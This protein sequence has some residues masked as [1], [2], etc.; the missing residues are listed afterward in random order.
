MMPASGRLYLYPAIAAQAD[1]DSLLCRLAWYFQAH[2]DRIAAIHMVAPRAMLDTA[3]LAPNIDPAVATMLPAVRRKMQPLDA[4]TF[5]KHLSAVDPKADILLLW[6][7]TA[8][9]EAPAPVRAAIKALGARQAFYRV[10]PQR[11]RMEGS[12]WLWAGLNRFADV[13]ALT[14]ANRARFQEMRAEIGHHDKAY[15]FG[16]GPSLTSF[17]ERH[18]FSDGLAIAANSIVK[19]AAVVARIRP[20]IIAA[21]DPLYHAGVSTYA[22]AF[23][24]ELVQALRDSGAWFV[25]P[26]RDFPIYDAVLPEDLRP[27]VI[28]IPFD[29]DAPP[30]HD[31]GATFALRPYPNVLTLALLPLAATFADRIDIVGCDGR[32]LTDDGFFWSHD[33]KVQFMD[34]MAEIQ[35]A[36]PAFFKIDYND[37]YSDHA[38]DV[39]IVAQ[40]LEAAGKRLVT[41]TPSRI[42]AL[43]AREPLAP[44][45]QPTLVMLD[46]DA[47]DDWGHFLAYDKRIAEG[48][49]ARGMRVALL[50]RNDLDPAFHPAS[51]AHTVPVFSVHSWA[52]G[53]RKTGDQH[54][55]DVLTFARALEAGLDRLETVI[56]TGPLCLFLYVGS[57]ELAEIVEHVIAARPRL[58]AVVN[59]FW[60]YNFDESDPAYRAR[61]QPVVARMQTGRTR[62]RLTHSTPQIA[63]DFQRHWG[64]NIP[65]L[66]HPSTTFGDAAA[67]ACAAALAAPA[68][69]AIPGS[70]LRVLFPGG[71]RQEKGFVLSL[72]TAAALAR[73]AALRPVLRTRLDKV[74]GAALHAAYAALDPTGIE[75][76]DQHLSDDDFIAMIAGADI[77]VLPYHAEAFRRRTSGILIDAIL[78]GKP[79]VVLEGTWLADLVAA[80]GTGE[81]APPTVEGIVAA[82]RRVAANYPAFRAALRRAAEAYV[83]E[84]GWTALVGTIVDLAASLPAAAVVPDTIQHHPVG[85]GTDPGS[86]GT[87]AVAGQGVAAAVPGT[88][89]LL[90]RLAADVPAGPGAARLFLLAGASALLTDP[91]TA[92]ARFEAGGPLAAAAEHAVARLGTTEALGAHFRRVHAFA[93]ARTGGRPTDP[94]LPQAAAHR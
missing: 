86:T 6:D 7:E 29:K 4:T 79:V 10:D 5:E 54:K 49:M 69:A 45:R 58:Q 48:C 70:P 56:P 51:M 88:G 53:N 84:N 68:P 89:D 90:D 87:I 85:A 63:A 59:L 16:T 36:H 12:F 17:V 11:T 43:H 71:A 77:V 55:A 2:L 44:P 25:C 60:S 28:G 18:D 30:P 34:K 50:C 1:A 42:P 75:I 65:V 33:Q 39:E 57:V 46:P 93:A 35:G 47:K 72:G 61:W 27:R 74:S 21:A 38:R 22:G 24:A 32:R 19:N 52:I 83:T 81:I 94:R 13:P 8:E 92:L 23:R 41:A 82:I 73:D 91:G 66:P 37:Y 78:L 14:A 67:A 40:T 76:L 15:V 26:L 64:I 3:G 20:R 31:L 62:L 80:E 9:A